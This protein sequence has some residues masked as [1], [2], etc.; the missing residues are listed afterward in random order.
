MTLHAR[1]KRLEHAVTGE[2]RSQLLKWIGNKQRQAP[3]I[4]AYCPNDCD[5]PVPQGLFA[6]E[7]FITVGRCMLQRFQRDGRSLASHDVRDRLFFDILTVPRRQ[8][9]TLLP[10]YAP[11]DPGELQAVQPGKRP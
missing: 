7:A 2:F 6:R 8:L 3:A 5:V 4:I 10:L 11:T 9:P 1:A